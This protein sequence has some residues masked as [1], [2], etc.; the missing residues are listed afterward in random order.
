[1][2]GRIRVLLLLLAAAHCAAR[3]DAQSFGVSP[4]SLN[5]GNVFVGSSASASFT[6]TASVG[7]GTGNFTVSSTNP[8]FTVNPSSFTTTANSNSQ[9]VLVTFQPPAAGAFSGT[10]NVR[11]QFGSQPASTTTVSVSGNGILPFT[12]TPSALDFGTI[13]AGTSS[14]RT[15]TV[16]N[17]TGGQAS[18]GVAASSSVF[19]AAPANFSLG[20]G[21]SITV[22]VTF[23]PNAATSFAAQLSISGSA[24]EIFS[25]T[26]TVS[27]TGTGSPPFTVTPASLSFGNVLLGCSASQTFTITP[28]I[29]L[30]I[31]LSSTNP[32]TYTVDSDSFLAQSSR[33][34]TVTFTPSAAGIAA[35]FINIVAQNTQGQ[36]L[37]R[38][39]VAVSGTGVDIVLSKSSLDFGT[40]NV[41]NTATQ[42]VQL[43]TNPSVAAGYQFAA[44]SSSSA[45]TAAVT[46]AGAAQITFKPSVGGPVTGTITFT[47]TDPGAPSS[48][49]L[50]RTLAVKG[51]G[52]VLN[53]TISPA[54]LDFGGVPAGNTSAP[55]TA[56]L[57]NKSGIDFTGTTS[58]GNAA[59]SVS[60]SSF[61]LSAGGQVTFAVTFKPPSVGPQSGTITFNLTSASAATGSF[62]TAVTLSVAGNGQAPADLAVSPASLDFGTIAVGSTASLTVSV[63]N[64]GGVQASVTASAGAP[65]SVSAT[66]FNL[67]AGGSQ[68]ITITFAPA[69][70]GSFQG[71]ATFST[72]S[73]TRTVALTGNAAAPS[74]SF[75][76]TAGSSVTPV[77]PGGSPVVFP[78]TAAGSS[79]PPVQFQISNTG[80]IPVT[81]NSIGIAPA[82]FALGAPPSL[83]ASIAPGGSLSFPITFQPKDPGRAA[84]TLSID[85]RAFNLSGTGLVAAATITGTGGAV[86]PA[87]QPNVGITLSRTYTVPL[88]GTLSLDFAPNAIGG[89][90]PMIQFAGGGTSVNF[91]IPANSNT[92][93]FGSS[94]QIGFQSG[95]VAGTIT[96]RATFQAGGADV[97]P[98]PAPA[99]SVTIARAAPAIVSAGVANRTSSGFQLVIV[100]LSTTREVNTVNV[101]FTPASGANLQTTSL[102]LDVGSLFANWYNSAAAAPFGSMATLTV[103]MNVQGD[104]NAVRSASIT[105]SNGNGTSQPVQVT[106]SP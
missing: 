21:Q 96:F 41:G 22:A 81:V 20:A 49:P 86:S 12:I 27:L 103:P 91:S 5:F 44:S 45:F 74:M 57:S 61:T 37:Q 104:V 10:I 26:Q 71:T 15:I 93:M 56:T 47:I 70:A 30:Q 55:M 39:F 17:Q 64:P 9:I 33:V 94:S 52:L 62:T 24:V 46:A 65:F 1:M 34:V 29:P 87:T 35:A 85:G 79:S 66:S 18:F 59:F 95:S 89:K 43:S 78:A 100:L 72:S 84:A 102:T 28:S 50:S 13:P 14:S 60:P 82:T 101:Q 67:A 25:L 3:L 73:T 76:V 4:N 58:S 42:N 7:Q 19:S 8:A 16:T 88:T 53:V 92:A 99:G 6:V 90:D 36:E 80:T 38:G 106:V 32:A 69:S 68:S 2:T 11:G 98:A 63:S 77:T 48:C 23:T 97:T 31:S 83:P 75:S 40:V 105:L 51:A 54:S